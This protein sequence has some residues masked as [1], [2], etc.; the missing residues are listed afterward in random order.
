MEYPEGCNTAMR[1]VARKVA[2]V[3][4][5]LVWFGGGFTIEM[6]FLDR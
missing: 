3:E 6:L 5:G 4:G 2:I 1:H